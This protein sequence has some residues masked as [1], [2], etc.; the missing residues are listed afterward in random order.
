MII[1]TLVCTGCNFSNLKIKGNVEKL[2]G[3]WVSQD[4]QNWVLS[5]KEDELFDRYRNEKEKCTYQI[6]EVSCDLKYTDEKGTFIKFHCKQEFCCEVLGLT[7][8]TFSYRETISGKNH[9]FKKVHHEFL[10]ILD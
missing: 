3:N 5:F 8:S 9:I 1:C 4:D 10:N 6:S 2:Q 7:D